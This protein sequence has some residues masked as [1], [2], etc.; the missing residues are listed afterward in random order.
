MPNLPRRQFLA[1]AFGGILGA[2]CRASSSGTSGDDTA[3]I[4]PLLSPA[5]LAARIADVKSGKLVVLYVGP[6][7]LF[8]KGRVP[9]ARLI[10]AL[11]SDEGRKG[12]QAALAG[13]SK[14]TE[15]VL[16]CGC[17]PVKSC[18]NVRPASAAVRALGR[19]NAWVLDLPTRFATDW[20]EKG[21]PVERS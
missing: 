6:P 1:A 9:G 16:Y 21:Y 2:S 5:T 12:L 14:D 18:P 3:A 20:S 13:I 10:G 19:P 8:D 11:D 4:G 17:C 15:V 7:V